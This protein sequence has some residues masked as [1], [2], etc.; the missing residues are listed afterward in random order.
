MA[1]D[2][3]AYLEA[4]MDACLAKPI[5]WDELSAAIGRHGAAPQPA[6]VAEPAGSLV[7]AQVLAGL[8]RVVG[9]D[10]MK[11]LV[12]LGMEAYR[13]YCAGM[14]SA[15]ADAEL[16]S[17]AH[18]LKGSAG[19]LGLPAISAAAVRIESAVAKGIDG[20]P[21]VRDLERTI[22]ATRLELV[23]L[24]ILHNKND[25]RPASPALAT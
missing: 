5:D 6:A 25:G 2:R 14:G 10:Q 9:D 4:G 11:S 16:R 17:G 22:E 21:L 3:D 15:A 18:K 19:T 12:R 1:R 20:A 24:G 13:D 23:R 7:D 8:A